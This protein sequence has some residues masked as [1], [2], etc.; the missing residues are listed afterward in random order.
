MCADHPELM[1]HSKLRGL[2]LCRSETH[3]DKTERQEGDWC[4]YRTVRPAGQ[5]TR[6]V[7]LPV[8]RH[9]RD[10]CLHDSDGRHQGAIS[11]GSRRGCWY[12]C[13][14][15]GGGAINKGRRWL[16]GMVGLIKPISQRNEPWWE[17]EEVVSLNSRWRSSIRE[18]MT[19]TKPPDRAG[20]LNSANDNINSHSACCCICT[21]AWRGEGKCKFTITYS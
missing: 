13:G 15:E 12:K 2:F 3:E 6:A 9:N 21:R 4:K 7:I 8:P 11:D 19:A 18:F 16:G 10:S 14:P 17:G 5:R 1:S 20:L